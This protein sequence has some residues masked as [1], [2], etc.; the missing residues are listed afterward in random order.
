MA[1]LCALAGLRVFLFAAAFPIFNHVDELGHYDLVRKF[2]RGHWPSRPSESLDEPTARVA[3][4][5]GTYEYLQNP[6]S[7][8]PPRHEPWKQSP[9][10]I[11]REV[12]RYTW[13]NFEAQSPPVYYFLAG[14]WH[15]LGEWLGFAEARLV[16]WVR[17][18]NPILYAG[19]V[20]LAYVYCRMGCGQRQEI[21]LG[22]PL[23][24]AFFPQDVFFGINNDV[25]SP[26]LLTATLIGLLKWWREERPAVWLSGAV[27]LGAGLT[28]LV[29][30]TNIGLL[31]VL[32]ALVA[33]RAWGRGTRRVPAARAIT[34][35]LAGVL[36]LG[37]W[38]A[39]NH[40]LYGDLTGSGPT[41][42]H[43]GWSPK[44]WGSIF[45]HP[46]FSPGPAWRYARHV[47]SIYWGGE[48]VWHGKLLATRAYELFYAY[49]SPLLL[50]AAAIG[51]CWRGR[52]ATIFAALN[53]AV[54]LLGFGFLAAV[55]VRFDF[56]R[57][58]VPTPDY[59]F[60][61][62][63]RLVIGTLVPFAVLYIEGISLLLRKVKWAAAPLVAVAALV[64]AVV[65]DEVLLTL[66]VFE[67]LFNWFHLPG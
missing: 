24:V 39:R 54:V 21:Y 65:V 44:P 57:S 58:N 28:V 15:R 32:A 50:L 47:M 12:A 34:V 5:Y 67:S 60:L 61:A 38:M 14:L 19:L 43:L 64:A 62:T 26:L 35:L 25:L 59:P 46:I 10:T 4:M 53:W 22:V 66:P 45:E 16:Y 20:Y 29:K 9:E 36:P 30:L 17:F 48:Y 49:S 51:C 13:V 56:G 18:L 42:A 27:G 8:H 55:S 63:G 1:V 33:S 41:L 11:R 31:A 37:L 2:S 7:V 6:A 23:L 3:V 52:S 40:S